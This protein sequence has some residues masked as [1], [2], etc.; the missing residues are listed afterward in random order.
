M[1]NLGRKKD[2]KNQTSTNFE[3]R[4]CG[5][6]YDG[7]NLTCSFYGSCV[8]AR[9]IMQNQVK[10]RKWSKTDS[11]KHSSTELP[12]DEGMGLI[13]TLRGEANKVTLS[14]RG[15]YCSILTTE[16]VCEVRTTEKGEEIWPFA[17]RSGITALRVRAIEWRPWSAEK[18]APPSRVASGSSTDTHTH[19]HTN[20]DKHCAT[21]FPTFCCSKHTHSLWAR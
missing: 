3:S 19:K 5:S 21:P 14:V 2:A 13:T 12:D 1:E 6:S 10:S 18:R 15:F 11:K 9:F 7:S 16:P 20:T 17:G 8:S 4:M